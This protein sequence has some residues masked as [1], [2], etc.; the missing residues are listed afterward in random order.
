LPE[1]ENPVRG[2]GVQTADFEDH[3]PAEQPDRPGDDQ[4]RLGVGPAGAAEQERPQVLHRPDTHQPALGQP[5]LEHPA[6]VGDRPVGGADHAACGDHGRRV[7]D[8]GPG[9]AE[10]GIGLQQG[11][12]VD[13]A[14]QRV[15]G[16]VEG[17]VESVGTTADAGLAN[18]G[19]RVADAAA[20]RRGRPGCPTA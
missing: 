1:P 11:V 13:P 19:P 18:D 16:Q 5:G 4:E 17:G 2:M 20:R 9:D 14:H 6:A 3:V 10:E 8:E 15:A 12:G 7:L